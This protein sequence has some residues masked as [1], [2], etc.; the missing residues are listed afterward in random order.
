MK[1][2]ILKYCELKGIT[3]YRFEKD[4]G[5]SVGTLNRMD[6]RNGI[7]SDKLRD[8]LMTY[9]DLSPDYLL[10]LSD[11]MLRE[12]YDPT[13]LLRENEEMRET[14]KIYKKIIEKLCSSP[15]NA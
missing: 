2:R 10:G 14:I 4:A 15:E 8:I 9:P 12:E 1:D 7:R 11:T 3:Q 5:L 13:P 6:D